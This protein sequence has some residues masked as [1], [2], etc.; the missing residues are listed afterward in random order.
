MGYHQISTPEASTI[1][2]VPTAANASI[3][4]YLNRDTSLITS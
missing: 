4:K 1:L 3:E 2:L